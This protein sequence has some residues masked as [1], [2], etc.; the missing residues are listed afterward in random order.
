MLPHDVGETR[1]RR[2]RSI[3]HTPLYKSNPPQASVKTVWFFFVKIKWFCPI[4]WL[5]LW[6]HPPFPMWQSNLQIK[7]GRWQLS[8]CWLVCPLPNSKLKSW[9][10]CRAPWKEVNRVNN[11]LRQHESGP[12]LH[13]R[14][15]HTGQGHSPVVVALNK[16][17]VCCGSLGKK[18]WN[19]PEVCW[20]LSQGPGAEK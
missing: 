8:Q 12:F 4:I 14:A 5:I 11:V 7:T 1:R 17:L 16:S 13:L 20:F 3:S 15:I 19:V 6:F 18:M 9:N 2:Q 10:Q